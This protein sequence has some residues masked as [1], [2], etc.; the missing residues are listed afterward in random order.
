MT[1]RAVSVTVNFA[2]SLVV[3]TMLL[4]ALM[5]ATSTLIETQQDR[6]V[7]SELRVVGERL[8]ASLMTADRLAESGATTI[9]IR[10][11]APRRVGGTGYEIQ[12]NT[13]ADD[14]ELVLEPTGDFSR[15]TVPFVNKTAVVPRSID[16]GDMQVVLTD[17]ETL[18]VLSDVN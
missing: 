6:T 14:S 4:S 17:D 16:G 7:R 2:L 3:A 10:T 12:V 5:F 15:V 11:E 18:E 9:T 13:S 8:A 1:D